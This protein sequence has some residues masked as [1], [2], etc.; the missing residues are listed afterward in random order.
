MAEYNT[1]YTMAAALKL[2]TD[3]GCVDLPG[4]SGAKASSLAWVKH[5]EEL[6]NV[7]DELGKSW[8]APFCRGYDDSTGAK[9][10]PVTVERGT[11]SDSYRM[12]R[13]VNGT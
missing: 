9:D 4:I 13:Q 2:E 1:G 7:N 3:M 5:K 11:P 6:E 8:P 10:Q 12:S